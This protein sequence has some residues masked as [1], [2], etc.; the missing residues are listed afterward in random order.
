MGGRLDRIYLFFAACYLAQGLS[1]LIYEPVSYLLKDGLGLGPAQSATFVWWMTLPMLVKPVFG[2]LSDL[3]PIRHRRR[4][5]HMAAACLLWAAS[6]AALAAYGR[7]RYG[8]LLALL[9]LVNVGLVFG[10]I[11]CDAV[12]VEQ[13]QRLGKTGPY[14]AVQIGVLYAT[15]V[16]TG[17]GGGWLAA[18]VETRLVFA[19]AACFPLLA[20]GSVVWLREPQAPSPSSGVGAL[21]AVLRSRR[22]WAVSAVIFIWSF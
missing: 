18:H 3:V 19:L 11:V 9:I 20:L 21:A 6:L 8:L 5:P 16:A 12:M 14:Q 10:D 4:R 15:I 22:F 13:G 17:I 7:P 2:L 1:G